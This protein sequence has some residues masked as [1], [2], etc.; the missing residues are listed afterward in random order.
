MS[1]NETPPPPASKFRPLD[2]LGPRGLQILRTSFW[3]L[4][5]KA[6]AAAN[7]FLSVPFVLHALGQNEFGVWATLVSFIAVSNFLDFGFGNGTMNLVAAARGRDAGPEIPIIV[8]ESQRALFKIAAYV[9]VIATAL[10]AFM[11]W[12]RLLGVPESMEGVARTASFMVLLSVVCAIPLNMANRVQLGLGQGDRAFRWQAAGQLTTLLVVIVVATQHGSLVA[13]TAATVLT[14]LLASAGNL[15]YLRRSL[16]AVSSAPLPAATQD[17][18]T[19]IRREGLSFFVLQLAA[20]L[21]FSMDLP[22]I[23]ALRGPSEAGVYALA[24]RLFSIIPMTLALVWAPLWPTYRHALA[25]GDHRWVYRTFKRSALVAGAYACCVGT[26]LAL[27][28]QPVTSIWLHHPAQASAWLLFGFA[29][30]CVVDAIG[31]AT[32]TLLNAASVLRYQLLLAVPFSL[33][34]FT[35]KAYA[36]THF[37]ADMLPW[38]TLTVYTLLV[39]LPLG[40]RVEH[41]R[42]TVAQSRY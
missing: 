25:S 16:P 31:T 21:A 5:A 4:I 18:A 11:P 41:I 29:L 9:A 2:H 35:C 20:S 7:L 8:R 22:L 3:S 42:E 10:G 37:G 12:H 34:T 24:Q 6:A 30:A 1:P 40:L 19:R 23:S 15:L 38:I 14:P 26:V 32:S 13:L 39:L 33:V 17:Y 36:L 27:A 28:Y